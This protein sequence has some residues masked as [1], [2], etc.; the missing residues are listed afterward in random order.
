MLSQKIKYT[1]QVISKYLATNAKIYVYTVMK[2]GNTMRVQILNLN[3]SIKDGLK[4]NQELK[5]KVVGL[6]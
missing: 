4:L 1:Y 2:L 6:R 3:F 5:R